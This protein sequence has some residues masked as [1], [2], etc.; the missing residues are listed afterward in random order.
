M[1]LPLVGLAIAGLGTAAAAYI[2]GSAVTA[3]INTSADKDVN[4]DILEDGG[5]SAAEKAMLLKV[6]NDSNNQNGIIVVRGDDD[7][8]DIIVDGDGNQ[9]N[10]TKETPDK[11]PGVLNTLLSSVGSSIIP[12]AVCGV[13]IL[14]L[15][16]G[17]KK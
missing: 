12:A 1:P 3:F 2:G 11:E 10:P 17:G 15:M 5:L 8:Q 13:G 6:L 7:R 9:T 14:L 4:K 16:K